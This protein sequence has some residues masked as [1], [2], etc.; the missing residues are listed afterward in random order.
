MAESTA[1]NGSGTNF[2]V[3]DRVQRASGKGPLGFVTS[4]RTDSLA[5]SSTREESGIL[6]GVQW[7]NGSYSFF[8]PT[9]LKHH[10]A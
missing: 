9:S 10:S 8:T 6:L 2:K 5:V 7:D 4:I 3:N 1:Q